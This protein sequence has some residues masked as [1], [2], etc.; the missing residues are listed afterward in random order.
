LHVYRY[1][2]G[3]NLLP[4]DP[5]EDTQCSE[6]GQAARDAP[7]APEQDAEKRACL[8]AFISDAK[9]AKESAATGLQFNVSLL[10]YL[11]ISLPDAL[12]S[13]IDEISQPIS[14]PQ[15]G[16]SEPDAANATPQTDSAHGTVGSTA[17]TDSATETI[18]EDKERAG[19]SGDA[20]G[21][22]D[23]LQF[24]DVEWSEAGDGV[25]EVVAGG[26]NIHTLNSERRLPESIRK[27]I[28]EA[29]RY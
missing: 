7:T 25:F 5:T 3:L 27:A 17:P 6:Q 2:K 8:G 4:R 18:C 16:T 1:L 11:N 20:L 24:E 13:I 10:H 22:D 19:T 29:L 21:A 15:A 23:Q 14:T 9:T 28:S 12:L 26:D